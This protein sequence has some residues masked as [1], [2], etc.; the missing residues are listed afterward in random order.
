MHQPDVERIKEY[1]Q[2]SEVQRRVQER[3][4]HARARVTVTISRAASL[5]GFTENQLREWERRGLL[6]AD[7]PELS[8]DGKTSAGHRQ[9]SP[10]EL[11]KLALIRELMDHNYGLNE[12]PRNID[13]IWKQVLSEQQSQLAHVTAQ[14]GRQVQEVEHLSLEKRLK[15]LDQGEFWRYFT[16]QALRLSLMLICEDIPDTLAGFIL[17]L[18][19]K[20]VSAIVRTPGDLSAV[21]PC[22]VGWLGWNHT[23]YAFLDTALTFDYP[24]DFRIE[25][26]RPV[27]QQRL[28]NYV[29]QDNVLIIVQRGARSLRLSA[30][31]VKTIGRLVDLLYENIEKWR[32]CFDYEMHDWLYQVTDFTNKVTS[33]DEILNN[34][35][36]IVIELGGKTA[37][38]ADR[39]W[40]CNLFLSRDI[41]LP[42]QKNNLV[43]RAHSKAAPIHVDTYV[44]SDNNPGLTFR[45][46][47]SGHIVYRSNITPQDPVLAYWEFERST[48]SAIAIPI[49]GR[50][51]LAIACL[52]VSSEHEDAFSKEDQRVLRVITRMMEELL[53]TY[54][55]R[56]QVTGKLSDL[57]VD[58]GLVDISFKEFLP[59]DEFI[60]DVEAILADI[61]RRDINELNPA[62]VLS[63]VDIDIDNLSGLATKYGNRVA[64]N[65][66]RAVGSRIQGQL[67]LESKNEQIKR[68]HV[69][70]DSYYLL[71]KGMT[72]EDARYLAD[73]LR[74]LGGDYRIDAR[75]V[76]A[77]PQLSPEDLLELPN[78]TIR[79][80]VQSYP[81][82]KLKEILQR[83]PAEIA[84]TKTR[85]LIME[86]IEESLTR[87][88]REGGNCIIS[89]DPEIWTYRRWSP[90]TPT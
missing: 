46:Y 70:A 50:D 39:W 58:P 33:P 2:N 37:N 87:G 74:R 66:S 88:Q 83:Y 24:S 75:G 72:L 12:I 36:N 89:W 6:R 67:R 56:S 55:A 62:D 52:Y 9:Y 73:R 16:A 47:R 44:L 63:F 27:G 65:L 40:F 61:H 69:N 85:V 26:L 1:L 45:A 20:N 5:F 41:S 10:D 78:V 51:G 19:R 77:Y 60:N 13:V 48:R 57:I 22:L 4:L 53:A 80:G 21:G 86:N 15:S 54:Q 43:V 84:I 14:S 35:A 25:F 68:Y 23:F 90:P 29:S 64:R 49:A 11:D 34:L 18:E 71:L 32:P 81:Y 3:I 59:E 82:V 28:E 7:R 42:L 8:Q 31:L 76:S 17:P 30:A 38:G 79:L